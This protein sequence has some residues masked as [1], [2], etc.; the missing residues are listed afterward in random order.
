M[1][2]PPVRHQQVHHPG[3]S[4][5]WKLTLREGTGVAAVAL[6]AYQRENIA[7]EVGVNGTGTS[8]VDFTSPRC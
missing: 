2:L 5:H 8:A 3:Y 1:G 6:A 4:Q 7:C